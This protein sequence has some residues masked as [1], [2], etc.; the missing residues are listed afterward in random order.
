V[1]HPEVP[2]EQRYLDNA[3]TQAQGM[4]DRAAELAKR[5]RVPNGPCLS[6]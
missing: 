3:Y 2:V 1:K 5:S 4:R 6:R